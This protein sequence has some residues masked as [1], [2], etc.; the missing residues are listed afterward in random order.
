[1]WLPCHTP[2]VGEGGG[3]SG[4][5]AG[6]TAKE[7]GVRDAAW[8]PLV[9]LPPLPPLPLGVTPHSSREGKDQALAHSPTPVC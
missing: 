3:S 6:D 4:E 5:G 9:Q 2:A 7:P 1:M 8:G